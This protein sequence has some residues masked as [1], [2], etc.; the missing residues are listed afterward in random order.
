[1]N[2]LLVHDAKINF[3]GDL[4]DCNAIDESTQK[5]DMQGKFIYPGWI[6][7][8]CHFIDLGR[9]YFTAALHACNSFD[10]VLMRSQEFQKSNERTWLLGRGWN[11][12]K[13]ADQGLPNKK[14]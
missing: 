3:V 4:A 12:T 11:N 8:H 13:W 5:I 14:Q 2:A 6:D 1:M 10:E 9:T 7:P